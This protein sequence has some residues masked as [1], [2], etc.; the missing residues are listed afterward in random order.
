LGGSKRRPFW[1]YLFG[2]LDPSVVYEDDLTRQR[3]RKMRV[4]IYFAVANEGTEAELLLLVPADPVA[5]VPEKLRTHEWE[6]VR[7]T[8]VDD[9]SLPVEPEAAL[10]AFRQQGYLLIGAVQGKITARRS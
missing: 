5:H 3:R 1:V 6:L 2:L 7:E 8:D 4:T 10:Q 9:P